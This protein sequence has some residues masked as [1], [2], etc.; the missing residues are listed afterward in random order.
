[1][2]ASC[3]CAPVTRTAAA[4]T[5]EDEETGGRNEGGVTGGTTGGGA[6]SGGASEVPAS[7][8]AG[9]DISGED[10]FASLIPAVAEVGPIS[11]IGGII[12]ALAVD[13]E[14][15]GLAIGA[16]TIPIDAPVENGG[17][18]GGVTGVNVDAGAVVE[19]GIVGG[20]IPVPAAACTGRSRFIESVSV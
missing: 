8:F 17:G 12:D 7:V 16:A 5:P 15:P 2:A 13:P 10:G 20:G 1:M 6:V 18:V 14:N 11:G 3:A 19:P 4:A 9:A